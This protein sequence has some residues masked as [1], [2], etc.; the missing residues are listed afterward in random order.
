VAALVVLLDPDHRPAGVEPWHPN[1]NLFRVAADGSVRWTAELLPNE[2]SA[3]CWTGVH[4]D[5]SLVAF[6]YSWECELDAETGRI[7]VARFTK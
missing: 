5:G 2:H 6:T 3:K 4:Y 1:P 7:L